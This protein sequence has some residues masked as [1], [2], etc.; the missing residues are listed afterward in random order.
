[1]KEGYFIQNQGA[2][3]FLTLTVTDW[4]DVF[5]R[6]AYRDILIDSLEYCRTNKGLVLYG[7]VIMSNHIH[8]IGQAANGK[9]SDLIRDFKKYTAQIILKQISESHE[10]RADWMLK[11]FEFSAK[12]NS[13]GSNYNFWQSNNHPEEIFSEDFMMTKLNYIHLNP[14]RAGWVEKASEYLYCS[15]SNY[16]KGEGL[17]EIDMFD[18]SFMK[19][20]DKQ[21]FNLYFEYW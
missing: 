7:Y 3:Y 18:I 21:N 12:M 8:L 6:K 19:D 14:V 9:L 16:T 20:N 10:S 5:T 4:V 15:A 13:K 1:M 2:I 17:I 11:R